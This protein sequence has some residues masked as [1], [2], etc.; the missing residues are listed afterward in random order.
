MI[1]HFSICIVM[2]SLCSVI[3]CHYKRTLKSGW[4]GYCNRHYIESVDVKQSMDKKHR[5]RSERFECS[6]PGCDNKSK[7]LDRILCFKHLNNQFKCTTKYCR[8]YAEYGQKCN[9][10]CKRDKNGKRVNECH[11]W[12]I[13]GILNEMD[14]ILKELEF[15]EFEEFIL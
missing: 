1:I 9:V 6:V 12:V 5:I 3:N 10:H 14:E 2:E 8:E 13:N 11:D 7:R 4:R 15:E